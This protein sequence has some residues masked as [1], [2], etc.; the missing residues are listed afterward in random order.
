MEP[1]RVSMFGRLSVRQG[2]VEL[3][4]L[5][6]RKVQEL[7]CYL[8]LHRTVPHNRE[9]LASIFWGNQTTA[10]SK[11]YLRQ[12]LWQ[13]QAA[14]DEMAGPREPT[15]LV[16][17]EWIQVNPAA[18]LW[19]DAAVLED[20][21]AAVQP[22]PGPQ[23]TAAQVWILEEA[24]RVYTGDLLE[25][26]FGDWCIYE[27]ERLQSMY[28]GALD[29]LVSHCEAGRN[30]TGGIAYAATILRYDRARERTYRQLMRLHY[31]A[32]DRT[33]ALRDYA[34]CVAALQEELGVEPAHSTVRLAEEIRA[35]RL[36]QPD[37]SLHAVALPALPG[38]AQPTLGA[39]SAGLDAGV[40]VGIGLAGL[41]SLAALG[42]Q[43]LQEL[44]RTLAYLQDGA[45]M[46]NVQ[47]ENC[48]QAIE[49]MLH[50]P[51]G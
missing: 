39:E 25:G 15:L 10:N 41:M 24:V 44:A 26:W 31:L 4:G 35:D 1:I 51:I 38:P 18:A 21:F 42:P 30:Y 36:T 2:S 5:E 13:L 37:A 6:G 11:K 49:R 19:V 43:S 14:L 7:L 8:L 40:N 12:A 50:P 23:L 22:I 34:A 20:A 48:L 46:L 32:G 9:R 28:L 27:R 45:R 17:D 16:D 29:K 33:R 3:A 47:V